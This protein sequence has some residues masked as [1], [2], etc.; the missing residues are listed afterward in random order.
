[1][2]R[3]YS[4]LFFLL[5]LSSFTSDAF[6]HPGRTDG[7]GGH[8]DSDTGE[9]HYHHGYTEHQHTDLDGDGV[10]DC[11]YDFQDKTDHTSR[12]SGSSGSY[13]TNVT[14]KPTPKPTPIPKIEKTEE[15]E[16]N[17]SPF[18]PIGL[19]AV[20][21]FLVMK[22]IKRKREERRVFI[23]EREKY[24]ELYGNISTLD[25]VGTD[26]SYYIGTDGLP[27]CRVAEHGEKWGGTF[28]FYVT[29]GGKR[30]HKRTCRVLIGRDFRQIN[31]EN[32]CYSRYHPCTRCHPTLPDMGWVQK[33]R[34]IEE[35]RRKY[36][37]PEPKK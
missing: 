13:H 33:Y 4:V 24:M 7:N 5:F 10:P 17:F 20:V 25:I 11:P 30:Y 34:E 2:K 26:H 37:I 1:M 18:I 8:Y 16:T 23:A 35:I 36:N 31:A 28:T 32:I 21:F 6:A 29:S 22:T 9:Y 27:A 3:F 14:P 15:D 12:S 19:S